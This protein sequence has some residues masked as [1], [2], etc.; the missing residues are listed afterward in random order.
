MKMN[1]DDGF[2]RYKIISF[3]GH[4]WIVEKKSNRITDVFLDKKIISYSKFPEDI[5][6]IAKLYKKC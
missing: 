4:R 1:D 2:V 5:K 6:A 3:S